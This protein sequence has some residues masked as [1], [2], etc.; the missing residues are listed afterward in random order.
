MKNRDILIREGR[1]GAPD[2]GDGDVT[3]LPEGATLILE[4][5]WKQMCEAAGSEKALVAALH[6]EDMR[7]AY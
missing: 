5:D 3:G 6:V 1:L 4:N 2:R 7:D